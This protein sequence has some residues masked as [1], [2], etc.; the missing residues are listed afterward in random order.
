VTDRVV[1]NVVF[2]CLRRLAAKAKTKKKNEMVLSPTIGDWWV[3]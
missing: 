2:D 3:G 1:W